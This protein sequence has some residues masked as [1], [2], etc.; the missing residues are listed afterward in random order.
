MLAREAATAN[1]YSSN[2]MQGQFDGFLMNT[3]WLPR[4]P[5]LNPLDFCLVLHAVEL[6]HFLSSNQAELYVFPVTMH[7][8]KSNRTY[9]R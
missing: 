6:T 1:V 2:L 9:S 5:D 7:S 3:E 8:I 4:S